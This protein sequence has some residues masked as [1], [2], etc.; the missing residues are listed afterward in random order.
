MKTEVKRHFDHLAKIYDKFKDKNKYYYSEIKKFLSENVPQNSRVLEVGCGTG[1]LLNYV[2]PSFGY[3]IDI[4]DR[5]IEQ[6]RKKFSH[7]LFETCE[8][9]NLSVPRKFEYVLMIDLLDHIHDIWDVLKGLETA[10]QEG[11]VLCIATINPAWQ[12]IFT[13]AEALKLKMPEGPHNFIP[14]NDI[15]NLLEIFDYKI[16]RKEM[17]FLVPKK[18]PLI[19]DFLNW[20]APKISI[21]RN[22]CAVQAI[23][24]RKT[25]PSSEHTYSCTIVV[26]CHNEEENVMRCAQT[27]PQ[28]GHGTEVIFVNDGS[29]DGTLD[30]LKEIEKK[31]PHVKVV[32]YL[33]NKGKG[34]A[35][36]EGFKASSGE[37]LM[38][39]DADLTVPASDLAEFYYVL[40]HHKGRFV[41]GSRLVY[42][43]ENQ[44]MRT[45]NLWGN[46]FFG[47]IMSW[48]LGQ[49]VSDT[50]CGTKALFK[51]DYF[52]IKMGKDKWG[53]Y[54][55]LF[56][57][58]QLNLK[59]AEVP[60]HYQMRTSGLS[61]MKTFRH[62]IL[63]ARMCLW[64]F[65]NL[66][67]A[68]KIR[69]LP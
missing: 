42:P 54:D 59:I 19:A 39:L 10:V 55:L 50:L 53:D 30:A 44:S 64:G 16:L 52:K 18:I 66:K 6:A 58:A 56:G 13:I 45:V 35:V 51:E 38:I 28:M 63:L 47:M 62:G 48:L 20:L 7:L 68:G 4:S 40:S 57:A 32:S 34:Y 1:E 24:A 17:R 31:S 3:G 9:E 29:T 41:N 26:P 69:R 60:I 49:H 65:F 36:R 46:Q 25:A 8:V 11:S 22:F 27:I 2:K 43:L 61:K 67:L 23:V 14:L 37:I 21:L 12:P 33:E 15:V 5:M